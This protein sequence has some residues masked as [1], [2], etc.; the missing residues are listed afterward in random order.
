MYVYSFKFRTFST[1]LCIF[2]VSL[3]LITDEWD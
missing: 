3:F 1:D 2:Y